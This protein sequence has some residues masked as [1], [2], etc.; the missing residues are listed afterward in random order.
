MSEIS[1]FRNFWATLTIY[2]SKESIFHVEFK[3]KQKKYTLL[4][5]NLIN[6][7][8][9]NSFYQNRGWPIIFDHKFLK[10]LLCIGFQIQFRPSFLEV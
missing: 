8:F 6:I 10:I 7:K 5:K 1:K 2:T 9:S 4:Q 3:F